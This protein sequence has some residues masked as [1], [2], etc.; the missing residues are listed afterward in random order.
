MKAKSLIITDNPIINDFRSYSNTI[1]L[2]RLNCSMLNNLKIK[3]VINFCSLNIFLTI[4]R[5]YSG[6]TKL[7]SFKFKYRAQV[8]LF[9]VL[10]LN[11]CKVYFSI[12]QVFIHTNL[13]HGEKTCVGMLPLLQKQ[14]NTLSLLESFNSVLINLSEG[15]ASNYSL[16]KACRYFFI[17]TLGVFFPFAS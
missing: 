4:L 1:V 17:L 5:N 3:K 12:E 2:R 10:S 15:I 14:K 8:S 11:S 16:F 7:N 9:K 6:F 13:L